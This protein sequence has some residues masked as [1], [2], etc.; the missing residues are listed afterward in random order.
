[1]RLPAFPIVPSARM[2]VILTLLAPIALV[3]AATA[4]SAWVVAPAAALALLLVML[5]DGWL[6]GRLHDLQLHVPSDTEVGQPA[7]IRVLADLDRSSNATPPEAALGFDARLGEG[8]VVTFPLAGKGEASTFA[9]EGAITPV[10]R[11]TGAFHDLWLRWPGPLGLGVRQVH[12]KLEETELRVWP[13]LS[14]T[15]S[16]VLQA[17]LRDAQFGLIARRIRGEGTQFEALSEYEAG[18]DRR[19]IDWKASARHTALYARENEAE[20]DNQIVFA[21]DC[22]QSM[23]E[24][25]DGLP[26][27]D[28]AVTA[29]L[30]ASYV[31]LKGGDRVA[32]F[33]F[34]DAP[35]VLTPFV[36]DTRAFHRLQTAAAGLDYTTREPNFT[37]ALATLT[38][39]LQRRSL[40][41]LFSDFT[42][43]TSAELMVESV[44]RLVRHH[45]VIFVTMVDTELEGL[46]TREPETVA[47]IATAVS[48]AS[49]AHQRAIVLQRLRQMGVDVIEAPHDTIGY[50]LIDRYLQAKRAEAIG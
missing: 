13:D 2:L 26:R 37:L 1:M 48:A 17:F 25:V 36:T 16:P 14:P 10:R 34:A 28:R 40:I 50:R 20:R 44:A 8:G 35:S 5:L 15:R 19:R 24:P 43:P 23:C 46:A 31:A 27:I 41:V 21:F 32:F 6:A 47:D 33:G 11:G 4:P 12:R 22:G 30:T 42:D 9:G 39:R 7:S 29:A 49:L 45:L 3:V 38:A 18:M